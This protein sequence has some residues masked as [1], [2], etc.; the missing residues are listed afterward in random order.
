MEEDS[1]V[2]LG[3][4]QKIHEVYQGIDMVDE[5]ITYF[6]SFRPEPVSTNIQEKAIAEVKETAVNVVLNVAEV[7]LNVVGYLVG[8]FE[9]K[10]N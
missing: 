5:D 10:K 7:G 9:S 4:F 8:W 1:F 2:I 3:N 6:I